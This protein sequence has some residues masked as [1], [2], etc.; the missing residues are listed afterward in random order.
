MDQVLNFLLVLVVAVVIAGSVGSLYASGLRLWAKGTV[1]AD[2]QAHLMPRIGSVICFGACVVIVM[3]AL[4][5]II[6]VF[7]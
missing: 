4:Y 1:D 5:L 7:H 2:G 6:P 3:F